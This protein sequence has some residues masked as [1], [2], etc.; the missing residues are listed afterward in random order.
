ML[1]RLLLLPRRPAPLVAAFVKLARDADYSRV[2]VRADATVAELKRAAIA[3]LRIEARPGN[4]TLALEQDAA[5]PAAARRKTPPP[6][7]LDVSLLVGEALAARLPARLIA[8]V[9]EAADNAAPALVPYWREGGDAPGPAE[10][11]AD[12]EAD[13]AVFLQGEQLWTAHT[14]G[15][16][17]ERRGYKITSLASARKALAAPGTRLVLRDPSAALVEDVSGLKRHRS[18]A[19]TAFEEL[20]NKA[21]A[22]DAGLSGRYGALLAA[23]DEREVV[24][25]HAT[26]GEAFV[27][28]DGLFLSKN[29]DVA[30]VNEAKQHLRTEDIGRVLA[31]LAKLRSV[32]AAPAGSFT[33]APDGL[34]PELAGR[35]LVAVVS[36]TNCSSE[37]AA[38]CRALRVHLLLRD[39]S[40]FRCLLA[41][42]EGR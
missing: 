38:E 5:A 2:E 13:F 21:V 9:H 19:S 30:L 22:C 12:S 39:G 1:R 7:P 34:V 29:G 33:S 41:E 18:N 35:S 11:P 27:S 17:G 8:T 40:G 28:A 36:S 4:V 26:T 3:E 6:P 37:T 31:T 25:R 20:A 15:E 42:D 14:T 10:Q 16:G 23:N 32:Q 24:F